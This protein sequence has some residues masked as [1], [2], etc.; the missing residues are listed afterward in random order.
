MSAPSPIVTS[1]AD[2]VGGA[3]VELHA[4]ERGIGDRQKKRD[5]SHPFVM[6]C[7]EE[8]VADGVKEEGVDRQPY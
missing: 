6:V 5:G 1:I 4:G 3:Q 8:S 7:V 2:A